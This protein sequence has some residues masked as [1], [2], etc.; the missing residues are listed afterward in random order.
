MSTRAAMIYV[1]VGLSLV[2]YVGLHFAT[3]RTLDVRVS[4]VETADTYSRRGGSG[5]AELVVTDR[6]TFGYIDIPGLT[7]AEA[8]RRALKPRARARIRVI[9]WMHGPLLARLSEQPNRPSI[10]D[11]EAR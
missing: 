9:D 11:A 3:A 6:G 1:L 5:T 8:M 2:G 7:D 4:G 10:I